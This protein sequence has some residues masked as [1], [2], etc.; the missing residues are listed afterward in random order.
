MSEIG[1]EENRAKIM[2]AEYISR[3]NRV[4]DYIDAN[5]AT[6][7][8]LNELANVAC[9]SPYH[10][11]RIFRVMM[12][13]PL[14]KY[15]QRIRVEKAATMLIDNPSKTITDIALEC[16]F[17]GSANFARTFRN[18]YR[19]SASQWR[20]SGY[21]EFS[22]NRKQNSKNS[23]PFSNIC[24]DYIVSSFYIDPTTKYLA[25]RISMKEKSEVKVEIR[26]MPEFH[27]AYVRHIGPYKGDVQLFE[28]LF[29]RLLGWAGPRG[30]LRFPETRVLSVYHDVPCITDEHRLRTSACITVPDYT[31]VE[32]EVGKMNIP[33]G[34]YAV[35][36]FEIKSDEFENAWN[37]LFGGWLP[38]SGFQPDDR[39][40]YDIS[41]NDHREHPQNKHTVDICL[42]VKPL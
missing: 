32:G 14:N 13:E 8:S 42:P 39:P 21:Y 6:E 3:V 2:R 12:G 33:G 30:L 35:A 24:K 38:E 18:I 36:R 31:A 26:E 16:G 11:H 15:I 40:C 1:T 4:I 7:L 29:A 10:F 41:L 28:N 23:Q 9:F 17:S 5:L 20:S 27:V 19:M 37:M 25:W 34:K 22:R